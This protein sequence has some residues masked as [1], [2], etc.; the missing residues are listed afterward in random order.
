MKLD[1]IQNSKRNIRFGLAARLVCTIL[2]FFVQKV[3]IRQLGAE[4]VGIRGLFTSILT[5]FSLAEMGFGSAIVFSMYKPIA[6]DNTEYLCALLNLYKKIYRRIGLLILAMSFLF[7]PIIPHLIHGSFPD[8]IDIYAVFVLFALQTILS[9][10]PFAYKAS[11]L[12]AYQRTDIISIIGLLISV[13]TSGIQIALLLLN[14]NYYVFLILSVI[15][16]ILNNVLTFCAVGRMF[17]NIQCKGD[18]P[19][20]ELSG[21]KKKVAGAFI[22]KLCGTTRNTFDSIFISAFI[23]LTQTGIYTSYY[24]VLIALNSF[25]EIF[26]RSLLAGVGNRIVLETKQQNHAEMMRLNRIY[27][28]ICG[29]MAIAMLCL[30]QPFMSLWIGSEN[31][32]PEPVMALFPIYFYVQ[33]MGDVRGVYSDA[34][35]LFWE[36]RSR[37]IVESIANILLNYLFAKWFGV[38]GI[39]LATIITLLFIG[40]LWSSEILF[41]HYYNFGLKSYLFSEGKYMF[42]NACIGGSCYFIC[43]RIMLNNNMLTLLLRLSVCIV[44]VPGLYWLFLHRGNEWREDLKWA[45]QLLC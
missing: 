24:Y 17:P 23:G 27:L 34:A 38:F 32:F 18:I 3:F 20:N 19:H 14:K 45:L 4:Y 33:K 5:V 12:Y 8:E 35:G 29:W 43:R 37:M 30:Y 42:M 6:E 44:L 15:S 9:Y 22:G 11:L 41:R 16:V 39:I 25:A 2:P 36:N 28:L 26:T 7:L 13:I 21:I 10:W 31:I 1:I 40:F